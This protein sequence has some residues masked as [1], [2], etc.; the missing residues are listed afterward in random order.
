MV[1]YDWMGFKFK[2]EVVGE[3]LEILTGIRYGRGVVRV[4]EGMLKVFQH[5][6]MGLDELWEVVKD[7]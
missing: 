6:R 3:L 2:V 1:F 7:W 5:E 4:L